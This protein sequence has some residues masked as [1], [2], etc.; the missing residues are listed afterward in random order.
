[1]CRFAGRTNAVNEGGASFNVYARVFVG[2]PGGFGARGFGGRMRRIGTQGCAPIGRL[3]SGG[4]LRAS[5]PLID[6]HVE[7][8]DDSP[9]QY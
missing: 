7:P 6:S 4:K 1:M 2:Q 3:G 5:V 8:V 9:G